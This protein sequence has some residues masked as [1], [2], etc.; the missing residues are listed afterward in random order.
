MA[1]EGEGKTYFVETYMRLG[2]LPY[3]PQ[4]L[5]P[6]LS[7]SANIDWLLFNEDGPLY[8]EFA[9]LYEALFKH[10]AKYVAFI[11]IPYFV[12]NLPLFAIQERSGDES[13]FSHGKR[14]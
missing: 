12:S 13:A 7:R 3:Y 11:H 2:G 8:G 5:R 14:N 6:N 10:G 4:N 1:E 9:E